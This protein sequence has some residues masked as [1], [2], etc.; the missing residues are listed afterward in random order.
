MPAAA[1]ASTDRSGAVAATS[2]GGSVVGGLA[3]RTSGGRGGPEGL[4]GTCI[5]GWR[6]RWYRRRD[7]GATA[8]ATLGVPVPL[9]GGLGRGAGRGQ[10]AHVRAL[11]LLLLV[12]L[13]ARLLLQANA[14]AEAAQPPCKGL[15]RAV[16]LVGV[17]LLLL[18]MAVGLLACAPKA[19]RTPSW[20]SGPGQ[21]MHVRVWAH[22]CV[23]V[24]MCLPSPDATAE[25]HPLA[26][27]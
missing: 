13:L 25:A 5:A 19:A 11:P 2:C 23:F 3:S 6:W 10:V 18:G 22:V 12:W 7:G 24:G 4:V 17:L 21:G 27:A 20:P 26:A 15:Q 9:L 14:K 8:S 16:A 1:D